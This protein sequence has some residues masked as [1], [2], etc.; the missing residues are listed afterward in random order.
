[1]VLGLIVNIFFLLIVVVENLEFLGI[2]NLLLGD[3]IIYLLNNLLFF[4]FNVSEKIKRDIWVDN[5]V[6][7]IYLLLNFND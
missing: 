1:M 6:D 5:Y 7:L 3:V 4:G 2:D